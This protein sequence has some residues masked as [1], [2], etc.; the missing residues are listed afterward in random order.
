MSPY[1]PAQ[2][3]TIRTASAVRPLAVLLLGVSSFV[4]AA[5]PAEACSCMPWTKFDDV[6]RKMPVVVVAQITDVG[7]GNS[8]QPTDPPF[9]DTQ[10]TWIA[11][12]SVADS[13]VRIWN[14]SAGSSC[15]GSFMKLVVGSRLVIAIEP[16]AP[17]RKDRELWWS[18][19]EITPGDVDY[20]ITGACSD[21]FKVLRTKKDLERYVGKRIR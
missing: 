18:P 3:M 20:V 14:G 16:V 17:V 6:T 8:Y 2:Q 12:G 11:K 10:V 7:P 4:A 1:N 13:K 9:I 15:G 19:N 21:D 5:S